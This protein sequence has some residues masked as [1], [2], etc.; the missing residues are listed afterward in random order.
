MGNKIV[1]WGPTI[2]EINYL[3]E[4]FSSVVHIAPLHREPAPDSSLPYSSSN[5]QFREVP[6][7]GGNSFL[8]KFGILGVLPAYLRAFHEEACKADVIHVR[9]PA[10]ISL[11]ALL[12]MT[13]HSHP[14]I[15]WVKYAGNW[16]SYKQEPFS[17]KFQRNYL[18]HNWHKGIVTINGRWPKQ[19]SHV[20]SFYNP[21]L[22]EEELAE[23]YK[24]AVSKEIGEPVN[25]LF[26]GRLEK[27]K[28]VDRAL[29]VAGLL[30]A[31]GVPFHFDMVGDGPERLGYE[32]LAAD[33]DV[34]DSVVF[35]GW[36]PK[37]ALAKFYAKSHLLILPS[38]SEGWP[39]VISEAMA[40]G[41]VPMASAVSSIPQILGELNVGRALPLDDTAFANKIIEYAE[42]P[43][44]WRQH[45]D[46]A[47]L[48][49]PHFSYKK[50]QEAVAHLLHINLEQSLTQASEIS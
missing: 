43:K 16:H 26:V 30:K 35:Q 13:A 11:T 10:N 32:K 40:Y 23:G 29:R 25:L 20:Y 24:I 46:A 33:N 5:I 42:N 7:A 8:T 38:L 45:R 21:C 39:K 12:W 2:R 50:Y 1:G 28:G 14:S 19:P 37:M 49:A 47:I 31:R 36:M 9:C 6:F 44:I 4:L 18:M 27:G 48:G 34:R 15:R 41:V 22:T 17:Y 3:S